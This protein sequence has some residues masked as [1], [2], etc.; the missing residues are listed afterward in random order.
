ME[1]HIDEDII[2]RVDVLRDTSN[3]QGVIGTY[4]MHICQ[5][6]KGSLAQFEDKF[7]V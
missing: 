1:V 6:Q 2:T 3:N 4:L 5:K 7:D